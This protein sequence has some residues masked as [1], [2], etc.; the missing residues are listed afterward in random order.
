[1][2]PLIPEQGSPENRI[3]YLDMIH[4]I[5]DS[6]WHLDLRR[7]RLDSVAMKPNSE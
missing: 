2:H 3:H 5:Y 7:R 6:F 4:T 1:M